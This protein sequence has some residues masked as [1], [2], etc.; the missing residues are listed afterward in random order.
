MTAARTRKRKT[1]PKAGMGLGL[2]LASP[3]GKCKMC[4]RVKA[5]DVCDSCRAKA[6]AEE[7]DCGGVY[8][9]SCY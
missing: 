8:C 7:S 3:D 6:H 1:E 9:P 5:F 4:R 2:V